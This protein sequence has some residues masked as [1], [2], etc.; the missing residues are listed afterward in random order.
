LLSVINQR[1]ATA[2]LSGFVLNL[3]RIFF[4]GTAALW[5]VGCCTLLL[6]EYH[7]FVVIN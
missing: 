3:L 2:V 5:V 7:W 6:A 4:C 1:R